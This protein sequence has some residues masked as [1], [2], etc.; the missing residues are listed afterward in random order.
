[1]PA[2]P[3]AL[4]LRLDETVATKLGQQLLYFPLV[5][6]WEDL[7]QIAQGGTLAGVLANVLQKERLVGIT[8][9]PT[10][11]RIG[12]ALAHVC[13]EASGEE[14]LPPYPFDGSNVD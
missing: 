12:A 11:T 3:A 13:V 10:F 6:L 5:E 2:S 1:M 9:E 7:Y 4:S 14:K 8:I